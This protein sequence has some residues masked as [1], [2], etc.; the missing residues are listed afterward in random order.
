LDRSAEI[1]GRVARALTASE[2]PLDLRVYQGAVNLLRA[3]P[4]EI[5]LPAITLE[6]ESELGLDWD[7]G[8]RSVM[9]VTVEAS[10]GVG[11][12]RLHGTEATYGRLVPDPERFPPTLAY[13]LRAL[14]RDAH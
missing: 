3:M 10:G 4:L 2:S 14:N 7:F 1:A 8:S 13:F 9:S 6:S 12:A 11:Y 5:P